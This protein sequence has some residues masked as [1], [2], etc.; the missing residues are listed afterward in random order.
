MTKIIKINAQ[1]K[2]GALLLSIML[3]LS[4]GLIVGSGLSFSAFNSLISARDKIKSIESYYAAES[5]L[6]DSLLR[7]K[8]GMLFPSPNSLSVENNST[9]VEIS[10]LIGGSQTITSRG[11]AD[12][13]I[14]K[15]SVAYLVTTDDVSFFYG[16]QV[17]EGGMIMG[18]N[19]RVEGNVFSNGS[20]LPLGGGVSEITDTVTIAINGNQIDSVNVGGDLYTHSCQDPDIT[21]VLHYV[22]GGSIVNCD[23][24]S[25]EDMGPNEIEAK[26]L[27]IPQEQIDNWKN[28]GTA[29][30]TLSGDYLL[31]GGADS[32]GPIR[33]TGNMIIDNKSTLNVTGLIYVE[34]NIIVRN[35]ATIKLDEQFGSTSGIIIS[36]GKITVGNSANLQGSGQEGSF[37]MLLST[38]ESLDIASPAVDVSNNAQGAIFYASQ[39]LIHLHN[40]ILIREATAYQIALD[41]NAVISYET[42]LENVNFTSGPGGSRRAENWREVE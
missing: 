25:S 36:N 6:E 39:G 30:G 8:E 5:G 12:G 33:I 37:I 28:D 34:G 17:G 24:G 21:G 22:S 31:D 20:I 41:N 7:L 27:P 23:Y 2:G 9:V 35:K 26:D 4:I 19:S 14:R 29:G 15:L 18:N 16:A 40:N 3:I 1:E 38:N 10:D 11:N 13:R 32:L 42:G